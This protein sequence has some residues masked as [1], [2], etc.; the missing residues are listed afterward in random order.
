[1]ESPFFASR[2]NPIR[3]GYV[4]Q[5]R[6]R[7]PAAKSRVVSIPVQFVRSE[8][9]EKTAKKPAA[10]AAVQ[11]P[12]EVD[13]AG[14]A[15][16]VQK[17]FRGFL[18]RK[19]VRLV[20]KVAAEVDEI[21]RKIRAEEEVIRRD[22]KER[23]RVN[24]MLMALLLRLDSVRGVRDYRK[25]VIRKVISLQDAVD[26]IAAARDEKEV[27]GETLGADI[28]APVETLESPAVAEEHRIVEE[29][30]PQECKD[31]ISETLDAQKE[32][33]KA[34]EDESLEETLEA[35]D[36][37]PEREEDLAEGP[38]T[39]E[40]KSVEVGNIGDPMEETLGNYPAD[41]A[42]LGT[43]GKTEEVVEE[44]ELK[45]EGAIFDPMEKER[46][47]EIGAEE[48]STTSDQMQ[49]VVE[50]PGVKEVMERVVAENE[51]LK[52]LV[53]ELCERSAQQCR[54]MGGLVE[55]VEHLERRMEKRRRK[56]MKR[57]HAENKY[58]LCS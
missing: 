31:G 55:R 41:T 18:V 7:P 8:E 56:N 2:R 15:V 50:S 42:P 10:A 49:G 34:E 24:E 54:L 30:V 4:A 32:E 51:R 23:L 48:R 45:E 39:I 47:T 12:A 35:K 17:V 13:R 43:G 29:A 33:A 21:E 14:A 22:E 40:S 37:A 5:P 36:E 28:G 3:Y 57:R 53:A 16:K 26:S 46:A 44:S 6:P 58:I 38:V 27:G 1:M 11:Q 20:H 52:G 19:N 9:E 25:K